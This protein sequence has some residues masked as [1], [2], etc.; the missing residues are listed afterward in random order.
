[1]RSLRPWLA[2]TCFAVMATL[3]NACGGSGGDGEST[4][5][6]DGGGGPSQGDDATTG[7]GDDGSIVRFNGGDGGTANGPDVNGPLVITPMNDVID[8][9]YGQAAQTVQF[10]A[11]INGYTVPASFAIDRG[12]MG[13]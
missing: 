11:T 2:V 3:G 8:V 12:E 10:G 7:F 4:T 6:R 13:T 9:T 5:E 1:M